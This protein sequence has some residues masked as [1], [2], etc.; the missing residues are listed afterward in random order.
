MSAYLCTYENIPQ[1][2]QYYFF[3]EGK[4]SRATLLESIAGVLQSGWR[5]AG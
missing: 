1:A 2:A 3:T 5:R 4:L